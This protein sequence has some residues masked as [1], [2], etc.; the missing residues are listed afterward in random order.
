MS[1]NTDPT[2]ETTEDTP[3]P[4]GAEDEH[5]DADDTKAQN[6]E[7]AKYR[8]RLRDAQAELKSVTAQL[9]AVQRQQAESLIAASG[10]KPE[11]IWAVTELAGVLDDDGSVSEE[12]IA[13]AV[14]A[15]RE[16]FGIAKP[17][18]GSLVP[19][20]GNQPIGNP[21]VNRWSEA[22]APKR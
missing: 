14:T 15:A 20:V 16:K 11:A 6:A 12:K 19:G 9:D 5:Q 17:A 7:A 3:A 13:E 2:P 10:V 4:E 21:R 18:K 1:E 8:R 22:F